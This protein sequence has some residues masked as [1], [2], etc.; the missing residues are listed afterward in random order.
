MISA[1][2]APGADQD[3]GLIQPAAVANVVEGTAGADLIDGGYS[4]DPEGDMVDAG[5]NAAGTDDDVIQGFGGDDTIRAGAGD[6]TIY[7]GDG[8][9]VVD[10]GAGNDVIYGFGDTLG[11]L[12]GGGNDTLLG[13]A[14]DD[15]LLGGAGNDSL[16]G[17]DGAD[18]LVGG[19]GND[20]FRVGAGDLAQGGEGRDGFTIDVGQ[21]GSGAATV[22][23]GETGNDFDALDGYV[24]PGRADLVFTGAEAGTLTAG[25]TTVTF[26][27]I[28]T[29][30]T[31]ESGDSVDGSA[32]TGGFNVSTSGGNDTITGSG[33]GDTINAGSQDDL[34]NAGAGN[35]AINAGSGADTV[36][37][38]AGN[39]TILLGGA[40]GAR[41]DGA[42]DV[43]VL[44]D[45]DGAD[46]VFDF[47]GAVTTGGVASSVDRLDV[48]GL[49][50]A[51]G[52]PVDVGDVTQMLVDSDGDGQFDD[53]VLTFAGGESVTLRGVGR[54]SAYTN[55]ELF[56]MGVPCFAAGTLIRTDRGE[57][58]AEDLAPGDLVLTADNG[59]QPVRWVGARR[60][61]ATVL[62]QHP[63]LRPIRLRKGALGDGLPC[64]DLVV[65]PQHR[66][67]VRSAIAQRMFGAPEVLVAAKQLLQ[68]DGIDIDD[69][70]EVTYVHFLCDRHEVVFSN[71]APTESLYTGAEALKAV[72][73]TARDEIFAIFPDLRDRDPADLPAAARPL[74]SGRMGR[75]LAVRH[76]QNRKALVL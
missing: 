49:T 30:V 46:N 27:E 4:G 66:V 23:G 20:L 43:L 58:A 63:N 39:D 40:G 13:G 17:G 19:D 74:L 6:D 52:N 3:N 67:L 25:A 11:G 56:A 50:D 7:A 45:G 15:T 62:A 37:G 5:D 72:G 51:D 21:A 70:A 22:M 24:L 31:G 69:A 47:E 76:A 54:D 48:S 26:S 41:G 44:A 71:G 12:D 57:V 28:E 73:A 60:L 1:D 16:D 18:A 10:G 33:Y 34:V 35:D 2:A 14:G 61:D 64:A 65:S 32:A 29:V 68:I 42:A 9:D 38:G 53:V 36:T 75:R 59:L 8:S 55:A